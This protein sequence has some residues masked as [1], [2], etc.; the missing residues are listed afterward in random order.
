MAR[1]DKTI[2]QTGY[3]AIADH[4]QHGEDQV[5]SRC[6]KLCNTSIADEYNGYNLKELQKDVMA[7]I[8]EGYN[9]IRIEQ[10]T[11]HA[12]TIK[13]GI[14]RWIQTSRKTY[15]YSHYLTK[16][17]KLINHPKTA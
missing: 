12:E 17:N 14:I 13:I 6:F 9:N 5:I 1:I 15:Q 11:S 10:V 7:A 16:L 3:Y 8:A 2:K 4:R